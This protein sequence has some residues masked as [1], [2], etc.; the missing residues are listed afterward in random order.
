MKM[1]NKNVHKSSKIGF[2]IYIEYIWF[3]LVWFYDISTIV[4]NLMPNPVFTY[5]LNMI[6]KH[7]F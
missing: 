6:C 2:Y 5:I 3:G 1:H 7:I 4:G